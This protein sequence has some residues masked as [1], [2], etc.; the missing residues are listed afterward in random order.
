MCASY[1][2]HASANN[3]ESIAHYRAIPIY[4]S[5]NQSLTF[6]RYSIQDSLGYLWISSGQGILRYN[7]YEYEN[8]ELR[9]L[10]DE[11]EFSL[12]YLYIDKEG[13]LWAGN[14]GLYKFNDKQQQFEK[15]TALI[16]RAIY[17]IE[18]DNKNNLWITGEDLGL[19]KFNKNTFES[20][21]II[22]PDGYD[23]TPRFISSVQ[24]DEKQNLLWVVSEK[25]IYTYNPLLQEAT[26][27]NT[28][29]DAYFGSFIVR[30]ISLDSENST[31]YIA[32]PRGL[33]S[34]DTNTYQS[35]VIVHTQVT[36][37]FTNHFTTTYLDSNNRLWVGL[38]KDGL[39]VLHNKTKQF[40]C[41]KSSFKQANK[42][43]FATVE[44]IFEDDNG[45]L[46]LSMNNLGL[47]RIT[48]KL[49]IFERLIQKVGFPPAN[50]FPH[51]NNGVIT[52]NN[53]IWFATDG[54]GIN[55][56][57]PIKNTLENLSHD[58]N[59]A[60]SLPTNS[61]ITLAKDSQG[62]I[63]GGTW[64]GGIF[65]VNPITK[66][67]TR[68]QH[69]PDLPEHATLASNDI[70]SLEFD[71]NNGLWISVWGKG[72]QYLS[73][74]RTKF[75][76]YNAR[77]N[78]EKIGLQSS[79]ITD[80]FL[81]DDKLFITGEG[82]IEVFDTETKEFEFLFTDS[83]PGFKDV[84]VHSLQQVLVGTRNGL[85]SF[86][87]LTKARTT[88]TDKDGLPSNEVNYSYLSESGSI[89]AAT[90]NGIA[91]LRPGNEVFV[92]YTSQ[93][94]L[95]DDKTSSHGEFL[96]F[97]N[98]LYIPTESGVSI[99]NNTSIF[100]DDFLP[101]THISKINIEND[102]SARTI[103]KGYQQDIEEPISL[104]YGFTKL[105]IH[106][107][108]LSYVFPQSNKYKYRL[109]GWND[110]FYETDAL[111]RSATYSNLPA[112]DYTFEV[113]SAG[114]NGRWNNTGDSIRLF[115]APAWYLTWWAIIFGI[116]LLI[117]LILFAFR[118]R[119]ALTIKRQNELSKSVETKTK[120]INSYAKKLENK[121]QE[122]EK[123]NV[124]LENRVKERTVEL[125][126][127]INERKSIESKLYHMA[128]HDSLTELTNRQWVIARI[129]EL[130]QKCHENQIKGY[131]VLFLDGDR[132]KHI[133]DS[134]GH[135]FGDNL[136]IEVSKRLSDLLNDSQYPSRLGGDEFT[137]IFENNGDQAELER[138]GQL[139]VT[140][141]KAPFNI[142][143]NV[144]YFNVSIG[145]LQCD[146]RYTSVP[147]VLRDADIAMY[148]AKELGKGTYRLF[149][150]EMRETKL[151]LAELETSLHKAIDEESFYLVYQPIINLK[152]RQIDG[153]EA[154]IRW[155][156]P[157]RG[158][159]SPE[160]FIPIAEETGLISKIGAWVLQQACNAVVS[161]H[162][163]DNIHIKPSISVNLS[164]KQLIESQFL[165]IL[166]NAI[167]SS[168]LPHEYLKLELTETVLIENNDNIRLVLDTIKQR[169]IQLAIDDFGTGYSSL[170]YLS[171]L[172]V[173][174]I[175]IDRSFIDAIDEKVPEEERLDA[176]Q[177]VNST[178][179]L[180][181][182]LRK[183]V[184][185]EGVETQSQL[186]FL[187]AGGCDFAQGYYID[188]PLK[189]ELAEARLKEGY[190]LP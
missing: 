3:T 119:L 29:L 94:G 69:D 83:S 5:S 190:N 32:T 180:S 103:I 184:T 28:S 85:V 110:D 165:P 153:F 178:I 107:S 27:I 183:K 56:Y 102:A 96:E 74:D 143:R 19:T 40:N 43:P 2:L 124:E 115:V 16:N 17:D 88:Y 25:G 73:S 86:N 159:I 144:V 114:N 160:I 41:L 90:T 60:N 42:L 181:H 152:T 128:F 54:G 99:V 113:I 76:T 141:F 179:A 93:S 75:T 91:I 125:E 81:F 49:E 22:F 172:P 8:F 52:E 147:L 20:E 170:S 162:D 109:V 136:L 182:G 146:K 62:N 151:E 59:D 104:K 150:Q 105:E 44:D 174:H 55:I 156:H 70:F 138:L 10:N 163:N 35:K 97:N 175:K 71:K 142:D 7:G 89:W 31:L 133:N 140:A 11:I 67:V 72:L 53:E 65:K 26:K 127:E 120:Q 34:I 118:W 64:G 117:S 82:G 167:A 145:I 87:Y 129:K 139:I 23:A 177:I 77:H 157:N 161:W 173:Q 50:Y 158:H 122:L 168:G 100:T 57:D 21:Q 61:I 155:E 101:K 33:L 39:C 148:R 38:E 37:S 9:H 134:Y 66:I 78:N 36:A 46:W 108:S 1:H 63:W 186:A 130:I 98:Q 47:V 121:R 84:H 135:S 132:F 189:P 24:F 164:F 123:L 149:D 111:Q 137:V 15:A 166:D 154:L 4:L 188:K 13:Q 126:L 14:R 185:A 45:S 112:G 79:D 176:L 58:V 169:K 12:A 95:A 6:T 51:T 80:M 187:I 131:G 68:Y 18:E 92:S 116:L 48:P 106:F 171:D 30:D